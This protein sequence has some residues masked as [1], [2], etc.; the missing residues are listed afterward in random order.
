V[1]SRPY[2]LL[3]SPQLLFYQVSVTVT[4]FL[5]HS[6]L[7]TPYDFQIAL[8]SYNLCT[9]HIPCAVHNGIFWNFETE[10]PRQGIGSSFSGYF[11]LL[12]L[13]FVCLYN[14]RDVL[15]RLNE[16]PFWKPNH[17]FNT[18]VVFTLRP[19]EYK[20]YKK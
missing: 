5:E 10:E 20:F 1:E 12:S 11:S 8:S 13:C 6:W 2:N 14:W 9:P 15:S 19:K 18:P 4:F 3:C 17:K 7:N 16:M